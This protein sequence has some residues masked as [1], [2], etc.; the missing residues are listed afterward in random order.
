MKLKSYLVSLFRPNFKSTFGVHNP[1]LLRH[2]FQL[3]LG[4]SQLRAHKKRHNFADTLTDSCLCKKGVEVTHH[5]LLV[6]P[7]FNVH[8][9]T[10]KANVTLT[11]DDNNLTGEQLSVNLLLYGHKLL[12]SAENGKII[13]H[14]LDSKSH[15]FFL[16]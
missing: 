4:L 11:L 6:C 5:F 14:A 10:L 2:L 16:K 7:F 8:R 3:R 15:Y 13:A 1:S 9:K 12:P